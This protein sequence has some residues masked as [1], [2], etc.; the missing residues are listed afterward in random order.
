MAAQVEPEILNGRRAFSVA[1]ELLAGQ[2]LSVLPTEI[3]IGWHDTAASPEVGAF[4]LIGIESGLDDWIGEVLLVQTNGRGC[5]VYVLG[6]ADVPTPL[7]LARRAFC[8]L[9]VLSTESLDALVAVIE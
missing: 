2:P 4:A 3:Q 7:S 6:T 1:Q 9:G 5:F 8:S